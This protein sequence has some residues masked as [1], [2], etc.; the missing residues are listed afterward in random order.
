LAEGGDANVV[1]ELLSEPRHQ[2]SPG[3]YSTTPRYLADARL[4]GATRGGLRFTSSARLVIVGEAL[5]GLGR[6]DQ[7]KAP[8][9]F[10]GG[11]VDGT[12]FATLRGTPE[13]VE[14]ST[15]SGFV[16]AA[17]E[18]L[19]KN[20]AVLPP[21]AAGLVPALAAGDR[22]RLNPELE[23][24]LRSAGLSHLTAVSGANFA[25]VLGTVGLVLRAVRLRRWAVGASCGVALC[26]FVAVVGPE[27]SVLRAGAMG[28]IALV[29]LA[30]GRRGTAC[31][32]LSAAVTVI[33]LVDPA[34]ALSYGFVL[35]V[36]ATLGITLLGPRLAAAL[37]AHAPAWIA[38]VVSVP[39]SA[40]LACGPV[41][42]LLDPSFQGWALLANIL[43]SPLVPP[44]TIAGTLSLALG[45]LCPPVAWLSVVAAG[46]PASVLAGLAHGMAALPGARLPWAE[47]PAGAAAMGAVSAVNLAL[48][49]LAGH[50][51]ADRLARQ[52]ASWIRGLVA[53]SAHGKVDP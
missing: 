13:R 4:L 53:R 26:A 23:Q 32:A 49:L 12:G 22:S 15:S 6:G 1:L 30:S 2:Q 3:L 31:A 41:V 14:S 42:V 52:P 11:R 39:L 44:I 17:R 10:K 46:P 5:E 28:A 19:R 29:A 35:S 40:Q 45:T 51:H 37:S 20:A 34:L 18:A 25:I 47:G 8:A 9:R 21:D 48:V 16:S 33:L 24:D 38:I 50:P 7:I 27:A 43:A 36:L